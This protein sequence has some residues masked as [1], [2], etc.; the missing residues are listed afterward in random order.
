MRKWV[1][2]ALAALCV[3]ALSYAQ[4][5][6]L[7]SRP[8]GAINDFAAILS[9]AARDSLERF[10]ISLHEKTG[11]ALVVATTQSLDGGD[12]DDVANKLYRKWGIGDGNSD[13]GVLVLI[14]VTDRRI[15][16][17]TGYGVEGFITDA[18]SSHII[19]NVAGP[20]LSADRWSDGLMAAAAALGELIAS[21]KHVPFD[22]ILLG[23]QMR[24]DAPAVSEHRIGPVQGLFILLAILFLLFTPVG[25]TILS[26]MILSSMMS[27]GRSF[28][29]G[30]FGGGFGGGSG[31]GFGG[32]GGGGSGGGGAS[33]R[34]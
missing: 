2:T 3:I 7:S 29:G 19:R 5:S 6:I 26:Y 24:R 11:V 33:G 32:F 34:F 1:L 25:R 18:H 8:S 12:I 27:S 16:I 20:F 30:G 21:E 9:P 22:E 14:S 23:A 17:E 28:R 10:S 4:T 15:R 13:E 31:G